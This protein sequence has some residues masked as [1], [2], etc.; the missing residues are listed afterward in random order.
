MP[1]A[2]FRHILVPTDG[3]EASVRAAQLA[4]RILTGLGGRLSLLY[5]VDV[6]VLKEL[7]RFGDK[8]EAEAEVELEEHGRHYLDFL[9]KEA[10]R[11]GLLAHTLIRKG[12][13]FEEITAAASELGADL[14]VMGHVGQRGPTRILLG[15]VTERVLDFAH[16]PVL[17]V[18]I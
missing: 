18:K 12:N 14:I 13:P 6:A 16:C 17:V 2:V 4:F 9:V 15:S 7:S 3:S 1:E 10:E 8:A 11:E 5:V